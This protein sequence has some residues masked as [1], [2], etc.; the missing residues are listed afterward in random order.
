[1]AGYLHL[2][3]TRGVRDRP[4]PRPE[5]WRAPRF[6]PSAELIPAWPTS[7]P[8][9]ELPLDSGDRRSHVDGA[10]QD[11]GQGIR[12]L[13]E[14]LGKGLDGEAGGVQACGHVLPAERARGRGPGERPDGKRCCNRPTVAI[15][16]EI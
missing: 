7:T 14:A 11:G 9:L 13:L 10:G 3:Q 4:G 5:A 16:D 12:H 2:L 1:M 8:S 6:L 15:L